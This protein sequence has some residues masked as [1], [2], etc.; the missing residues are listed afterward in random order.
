MRTKI[1]A[2][3]WKMNKNSEETEDLL[4]EL[5]LLQDTDAEKI[6]TT[7]LIHPLVFGDFLDFNDFFDTANTHQCPIY[8]DGTSA[9]KSRSERDHAAIFWAFGICY[10]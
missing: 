8:N 6:D 10:N 7:L 3:N 9:G 1:V 4:N 5:R 2:G